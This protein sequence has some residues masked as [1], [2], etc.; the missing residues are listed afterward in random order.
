MPHTEF[1]VANAATHRQQLIALNVEYMNWVL[2]S[3]ERHFG[4]R[5]QDALGM[6]IEEYVPSAIDKVCGDPPPKG[7]FYLVEV[8]GNVVGMGGI[9]YL[10]DGV[11][12]VKRIY[13]RPAARGNGLG[14]R[15]LSRLLSDARSFGYQNI[16][17]DTGP[18]MKSAH[19]IY[20]ACG[21]SDCAPYPGTEVPNAFHSGWRFMQRA[22]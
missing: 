17:L 20:E 3:V 9:R 18:F 1:I 21:F 19:R 2:Q 15:M 10:R 11:A 14:A 8:E 16:C 13:F 22:L 5:A 12:E 4:V 7:V 6:R